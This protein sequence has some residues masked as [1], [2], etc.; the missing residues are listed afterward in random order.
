MQFVS[1]LAMVPVPPP[2]SLGIVRS[3]NILKIFVGFFHPS[4]FLV[5]VQSQLS[6]LVD[7]SIMTCFAPWFFSIGV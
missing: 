6:S 1:Q 3:L 4:F 5:M 7:S 2:G